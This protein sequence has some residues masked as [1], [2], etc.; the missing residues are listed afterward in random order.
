MNE[1]VEGTCDDC[2]SRRG[3]FD[4]LT[5]EESVILCN[6][7]KKLSFQPG[8][9]LIKQ[10]NAASYIG[11]LRKGLVKVAFQSRGQNLIL[12]LETTGAFLGLPVL[13]KSKVFPYSVI[14]VGSTECCQFDIS[15]FQQVIRMNGEFSARVTEHMNDYTLRSFERL[16]TL[17]AKQL[18]GRFADILLC[19]RNRIYGVP[20]FTL[21]LTRKDLAEISNMT[22]ESLSRVIRDFKDDGIC[23]IEGRE[24]RILNMEK[25]E[26]ISHL[27]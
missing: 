8:E 13:F 18:H 6:N 15:N 25:L 21:D 23:L 5:E 12:S 14:S 27:G 4:C 17:T 16:H 2:S 3:F 22:T 10:G 19:L 11:L 24:V 7:R 26:Q 20:S 9:Y 1:Q